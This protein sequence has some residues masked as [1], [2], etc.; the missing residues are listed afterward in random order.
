[1]EDETN[2]NVSDGFIPVFMVHLVSDLKVRNLN[3]P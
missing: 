2:S 1:M 3:S